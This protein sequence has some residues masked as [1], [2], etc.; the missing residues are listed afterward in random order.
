MRFIRLI[1]NPVMLKELRGQMRGWRA[2]AVLTVYLLLL[3][4]VTIVLYL[5]VYTT[6][7]AAGVGGTLIG[8]RVGRTLFSGI[9]LLEL[10]L[11]CFIAPAFTVGAISG[12]RERLTYDLLVIT[13]LRPRSIVAGKLGAALAY[14]VLLILAAL[15][16]QSLAFIL[17]GVSPA[18]LFIAQ[19][20]LLVTAL[21]SAS[22]GLFFSS[23]VRSTFL[24][25]V[26]TYSVILFVTGGL[27]AIILMILIPLTGLWGST[28]PSWPIQA[29]LIYGLGFL[30]CTNPF[31]TAVLTEVVLLEKNAWLFFTVAV[32][33]H[34]LPLVSPWAVYVLL[35]LLASL[36]LI[37]SSVRL[38][39][40]PRL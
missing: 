38:V 33:G 31:I 18:E 32:D 25:T 6:Y 4:C 3:S 35:C 28:T 10:L 21:I 36:L 20:G 12:E 22:L 15:P 14:V 40:A 19:S 13:L 17:G 26:L 9:V 27:P 8:V 37:A 11:M 23:L 39:R 34:G 29:L 2:F 5:A 16:L 30:A 24:S 7:S 1:P